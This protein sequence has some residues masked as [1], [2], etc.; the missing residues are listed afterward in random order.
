MV[1][2]IRKVAVLGAGNMGSGIAQACAQAGLEVALRDMS[3]DLARKGFGRI[4]SGLKKRVAD[5]KMAAADADAI[6]A[7]LHPTG[8]VARAVKDADL[9]IEA[10]FEDMKV[11]QDVFREVSRHAP[12]HAIFATN[13]SSLSVTDMANVTDRPDRF[14]GLHF[15][16]P[17]M[18]NKLVEVV[19]GRDTSEETFKA[20]M[21]FSRAIG[22]VPIET[23]DAAG[24]AVNR[25]FV[26]FLNEAV[27]IVEEG[28][29]DIPTVEAAAKEAF[30]IGMGPFELMNVTGV[31]IALHAQTTLHKA[32]GPAYAPAALLAKQVAAKANWDLAGAPDA[33]K[34]QAV[35]DR[36][37]GLAFGIA[38][39]LV[40]EG[41]ATR[42]DTDKGATIGLRWAKGPF[43]MMNALGTAKALA[44]VEGHAK[45]W[46]AEFP[47][48]R[49]LVEHGRRGEAFALPLV[50]T[51]VENHVAVV[52]IDRPDAL[53]ALNGQVLADLEAAFAALAK[54]DDVR[55]VVLTG[56]GQKAFVAGADIRFMATKTPLEARAFTAMG[57]RVFRAI[58]TF[59]RPV[60]AAVNGFALGG[61]LELAMSCDIVVASENAQF[62]LPEVTLGIH[63]GFGG[64]QRLPRLIGP[65]KA[66]ELVYTARRFDARE[67]ERLGLVLKVVPAGQALKESK[68]LAATIA[69]QAPVAVS[70]AKSAMNRGFETDIETGLGYEL[71]AVSLTFS[72]EDQKQAMKAFIEKGKYAFQGR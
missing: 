5:G 18:I 23:A 33:A 24:F 48:A 59:P 34:T 7:R 63:P 25:F 2:E 35:K 9:V 42:V 57:Q 38:A 21:A 47:V 27:R 8:D 54:D 72:T 29:A 62:G 61:G 28:V 1:R 36:L 52:T 58:E 55:A 6:L 60:I 26:P 37:L 43:A 66:K 13:T 14:G 51:E 68:A 71:E 17:A 10:V 67:A 11:K 53:N 19:K 50:R 22:K 65:M 3:D 32:F 15:F 69:L 49:S 4:E 30:A 40:E 16:Y 70:L 12:A 64:T 41:V 31:P 56:E 44:V 46:G 45:R 39:Q 20:L